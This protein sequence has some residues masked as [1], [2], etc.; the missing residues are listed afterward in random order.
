MRII[1]L[2]EKFEPKPVLYG[3]DYSN[4]EF[5]TLPIG[6]FTFFKNNDNSYYIGFENLGDSTVNVGFGEQEEGSTELDYNSMMDRSGKN[7]PFQLFNNVL[8]IIT[9][10]FS[11]KHDIEIVFGGADSK[12]HRMYSKALQSKSVKEFL[13]NNDIEVKGT[14]KIFGSEVF[15]LYKH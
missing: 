10:Y 7:T 14:K 13:H 3:T 1:D 5:L 8:Y 15:T 11:D 12:L 2:F 9:E 4:K 6:K